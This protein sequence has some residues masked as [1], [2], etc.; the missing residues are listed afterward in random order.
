MNTTETAVVTTT[1]EVTK[2]T[3]GPGRPKAVLK[4]PRGSFTFAEIYELNKGSGK[5]AKVC[6]LTVRNHIKASL[7]NGFLTKLDEKVETGK[8]GQPALRYIRT[9]MKQAAVARAAARAAEKT[10]GGTTPTETP[11][12]EVSLVETPSAEAVPAVEVPATA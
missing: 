2:S 1:A 7:A 11:V 9:A 8:P 5:Q 10:D 6:E 3:K 4:Y 12:V